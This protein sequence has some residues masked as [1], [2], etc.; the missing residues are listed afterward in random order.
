MTAC[1]FDLDGVLTTTERVHAAAW[2]QA[3]DEVLATH[4]GEPGVDS[5]PFDKA[6]DYH[7]YVDGK[8]RY[9]GV[10]SFLTARGLNLPEGT[11]TDDEGDT[12]RSV[13][14]R[15]NAQMLSLIAS[16]G[17]DPF[18]GSVRYLEQAKAAGLRI[19]V[20]SSSANAEAILAAAGLTEFIELRVD[21]RT[22]IEEKIPGKPAPDMFLVAAERLD[23]TTET[24]VVFE[25]AIS[26]VKA[27][28]AG[29]FATVVGV[30]RGGQPD[31][32][33]AAGATIVVDD[34][35]DLLDGSDG[36]AAVPAS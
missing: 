34:L 17:V 22:A 26:G 32:L 2:K 16:E 29:G 18:P 4:A 35:A 14:D 30:D 3:F 31:A 19:A 1:L 11:G 27:G 15:K 36:P 12:V 28:A 24:A 9:D 20:V 21:G 5:T 7:L 10:R 13:G 8:P 25:D 23:A 33:R 6:T